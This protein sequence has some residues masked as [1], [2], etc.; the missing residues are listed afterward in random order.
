MSQ[1]LFLGVDV[2]TQSLRAG[3]FTSAGRA[4]AARFAADH[5]RLL[6]DAPAEAVAARR[7]PPRP[8]LGPVPSADVR[9]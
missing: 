9:R 1:P 7:L 6:A 4:L 2:G 3:L 8:S 5:A